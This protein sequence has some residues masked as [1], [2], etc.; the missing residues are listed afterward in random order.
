MTIG[1][2]IAHAVIIRHSRIAVLAL[3]IFSQPVPHASD[4]DPDIGDLIADLGEL[5][6][7]LGV[8]ILSLQSQVGGRQFRAGLA[9]LQNL[10]GGF[11]DVYVVLNRRPDAKAPTAH[12]PDDDERVKDILQFYSGDAFGEI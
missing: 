2:F 1:A 12:R 4:Q 6:P 11:V 3:A 10:D 5:R 9:L 8:D 7:R